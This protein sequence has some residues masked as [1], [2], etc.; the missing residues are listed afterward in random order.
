MVSMATVLS[1]FNESMQWNGMS[2]V[3]Y[4]E[5]GIRFS[6]YKYVLISHAYLYVLISHTYLYE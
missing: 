3:V 6:H 4:S 1:L 2:A 5:V